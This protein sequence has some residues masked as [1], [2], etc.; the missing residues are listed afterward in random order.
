MCQRCGSAE[1]WVSPVR[2][3]HACGGSWRFPGLVIRALKGG[4]DRPGG[5]CRVWGP[6]CLRAPARCCQGVPPWRRRGALS[7]ASA[8]KRGT[9][10][11]AQ[12]PCPLPPAP[13]PGS[14]RSGNCPP[15]GQAWAHFCLLF[16]WPPSGESGPQVQGPAS[17]LPFPAPGPH[18]PRAAR[19]P[20]GGGPAG[21]VAVCSFGP[22]GSSRPGPHG[23][24]CPSP[25]SLPGARGDTG[26]VGGEEK[27]PRAR[28]ASPC[29]PSCP[30]VL[31]RR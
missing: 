15:S 18:A 29:G 21:P 28:T 20:V 25:A 19:G 23:T 26:T 16:V 8:G 13:A 24:A 14:K 27:A 30:H 7:S 2:R 4:A 5:R 17:P 11:S 9:R 1:P 31:G 22:P 10:S 12:T 6:R 3:L